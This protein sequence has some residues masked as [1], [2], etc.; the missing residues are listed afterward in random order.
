MKI[1][2]NWL[3]EYCNFDLSPQAL[4]DALTEAGL[5]VE[6]LKPLE[7]DHCL[8]V[9]VTSNRPDCLGFLGIAREVAAITR[10]KLKPPEADYTAEKLPVDFK[11]RVEDSESCPHYTARIICG[12]KVGPSPPWLQRHLEAVGLR[13]VNNVVDVTNYV[14]LES[15]QPLHAFDMDKLLDKRLVIRRAASGEAL[16][17]IDGTRHDLTPETLVIA[18]G[19]RPVAI[20]GVMGGID[21]EVGDSTTNVLLESA[22]FKPSTV[23][24]A[25]KRFVMSTDSSYRF[26][27]GVDPEGV[28]W[29][30]RRAARLIQE[31]AGGKVCRDV[32]DIGSRKFKK[33][34]VSV[35]MRR[36]NGLL[37]TE[38]K[39]ATAGDILSRLGFEVKVRKE[40]LDVTVPSFRGDIT[41]EVDLIEEVARIY[42]YNNIP[43]DTRLSIQVKPQNRYGQVE[44]MARELLTG[45]GLTEVIT[46]SIVDKT[47]YRRPGTSSKNAPALTLRN[48]I[49]K[50]EDRLRQTLMGNLLGVKRHNQ[51]RGVPHIKIFEISRVYFP[52]E[53]ARKLPDEKTCLCVLWEEEGVA[54]EEAF[55][56]LKGVL[57]GM[58][59]TLGLRGVLTWQGHPGG[60]FDEKRSCRVEYE[61]KELG[62]FGEIKKK[63]VEE[64]D[65]NFSPVMAEL[66]FDAIV[67]RADLSTVFKKLPLYPSAVRDMAVVV[68]EQVSWADIRRCIEESGLEYLESIEFFD[69]YHGR[70]VPPGKKSLAFKL[71]YRANDRTLRGEEVGEMQKLVEER[72]TREL[73]AALR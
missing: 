21:T 34:V 58:F 54:P 28:D 36:L 41:R 20:A 55:Y 50:G 25:A 18:D 72:L 24:R 67:E 45:W 32:I 30:S 62:V 38:I 40:R 16:K 70:Q 43:T 10:G 15:S 66:D 3:K 26:E 52:T 48:P 7:D 59:A 44:E 14:L 22:R 27:R 69:L 35:R 12:V 37:G 1:S 56:V 13:P 73:G 64:Y 61:G 46:Y 68:D 65:L 6:E 11:V 5:V 47:Q 17:T 8:D 29:A 71:C 39:P 51:D 57:E 42:G 9:E 49:R 4:A 2:Y 31:L 60:P 33:P 19:Q 53:S 23:R 63:V